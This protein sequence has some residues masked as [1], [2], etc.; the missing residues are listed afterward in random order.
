MADGGALR[1]RFDLDIFFNAFFM[2]RVPGTLQ[3]FSETRK[4]YC[5]ADRKAEE[6][7]KTPREDDQAEAGA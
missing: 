1:P 2:D 6:P 4:T 7:S 3:V 5:V